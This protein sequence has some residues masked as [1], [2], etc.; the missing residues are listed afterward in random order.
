MCSIEG[1]HDI[2]FG[3]NGAGCRRQEMFDSAQ[4]YEKINESV[5]T[6]RTVETGRGVSGQTLV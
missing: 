5:W 6:G 1:K 3:P 4:L 2:P